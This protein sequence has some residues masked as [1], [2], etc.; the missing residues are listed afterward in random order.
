MGIIKKVVIGEKPNYKKT[1]KE[2][3]A[4]DAFQGMR[5][6][7]KADRNEKVGRVVETVRHPGKA[8]GNKAKGAV[9]AGGSRLTAATIGKMSEKVKVRT[10]GICS[11]C[12]QPN[13]PKHPC[14]G[15][16]VNLTD[17]ASVKAEIERLRKK[18]GGPGARP[19]NND[20]VG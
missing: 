11:T 9:K 8:A 7:A 6:Q 18:Y 4:V 5:D 3:G 15:G 13:T 1:G 20:D 2:R 12:A 10:F 17:Q 14:R 16:R 19:K